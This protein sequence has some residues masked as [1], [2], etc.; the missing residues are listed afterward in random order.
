[1]VAYV[2]TI[3]QVQQTLSFVALG[4][5]FAVG[6]TFNHFL[7]GALLVFFDHP[8]DIGDRVDVYNMAASISV[9]C[10]VKRQ[11][12]LYT[13]FRRMDNGVDL[14]ISN[15]RLLQKRTE[16]FSR[17]GVNRQGVSLF[18]SFKTS[19]EDI[20]YLRQE[21]E[22]FVAENKRDYMPD[23]AVSVVNLHELNKIEIKCSVAHKS[24]WGNEK[25]RASRSNR[26]YLALVAA[27]RKIPLDKPGGALSTGEE[28]K[29]M[30]TV[31]LTDAEGVR[32]MQTAAA[33]RTVDR[34]DST[35]EPSAQ[36]LAAREK[37]RVALAKLQRRPPPEKS[38]TL[39]A[40]TA[41]EVNEF[42]GISTT[43]LRQKHGGGDDVLLRQFVGTR[44]TSS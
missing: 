16:N 41:I 30:F 13:V 31:P 2:P 44:G 26:F 1:M 37:E 40:S 28:G 27:I 19:F 29:P 20:V 39:A 21:L 32:Q 25:L 24:N 36:K 17:S 14:Q 10:V 4:L 35:A 34:I 23:L 18:V 5:A 15:E 8:F 6:R 33:N 12:L 42:I 9:A 7:A 3:K 43:G 22:A 38:N 11:S